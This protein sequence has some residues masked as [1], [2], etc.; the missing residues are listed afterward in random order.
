[1]GKWLTNAN[2]QIAHWLRMGISPQRLA[3]TLALGF[4]IGCLPIVGVPTALC[5]VV[6]IRFGLNVPVIQA[7]NYVAMPFQF[8]LILPLARLGR[9]MFSAGQQ[10]ELGHGS[11]LQMVWASGHAASHALAAWL[12]LAGPMVLL[13]TL[14]LTPVLERI[15][16]LATRRAD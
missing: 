7:A 16:V 11:V 9:W 8:A 4:A 1:M 10:P 14:A 13:M 2:V 6:A 15:P 12:L 5:A 3:L